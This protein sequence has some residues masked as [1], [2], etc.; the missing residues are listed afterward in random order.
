MNDGTTEFNSLQ[1]QDAILLKSRMLCAENLLLVVYQ[2]QGN[3]KLF[4]LLAN[5]MTYTIR[6]LVHT[7]KKTTTTTEQVDV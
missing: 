4:N 3:S 1:D 7:Y 2:E 6:K 5:Q